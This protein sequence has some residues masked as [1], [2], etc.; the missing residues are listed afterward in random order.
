MSDLVERLGMEFYRFETPGETLRG[1][2]EEIDTVAIQGRPTIRY[3]IDDTETKRTYSLLG[4]VD[5]NS[6]I[7]KCDVGK[8]IEIRFENR[9][10]LPG[11][12]PIKRFRVCLR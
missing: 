1:V 4:T 6:K 8:F 12:Y 9:E 5:L 10:R 11:K 7:Q 3:R 2:L